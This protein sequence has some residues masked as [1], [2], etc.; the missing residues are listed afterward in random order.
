MMGSCGNER[1]WEGQPCLAMFRAR[2]P[3][4]R[5]DVF[6][7]EC[8]ATVMKEGSEGMDYPWQPLQERDEGLE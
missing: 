6:L 2:L 1:Q 7:E 3:S 5:R 4:G 8:S